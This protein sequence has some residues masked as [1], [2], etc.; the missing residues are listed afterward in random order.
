[1]N[2]CQDIRTRRRQEQDKLTQLGK[3]INAIK[4]VLKKMEMVLTNLVQRRS[5]LKQQLIPLMN[6]TGELS[7]EDQQ[8][9]RTLHKDQEKMTKSLSKAQHDCQ[10][11]EAAIQKMEQEI[12][13]GC[14]SELRNQKN[15]VDT[16]RSE[17]ENKN[18]QITKMKVETEKCRKKTNKQQ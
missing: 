13:D 17:F 6:E 18:R 3:D 14:G 15:I 1:M 5:D 11:L 7:T 9:L 2:K 4:L 12:L 8:R 10:S 16:L